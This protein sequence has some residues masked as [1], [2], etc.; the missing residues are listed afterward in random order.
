MRYKQLTVKKRIVM[1][2]KQKQPNCTQNAT[3]FP[4]GHGSTVTTRAADCGRV[5]QAHRA[6]QPELPVWRQPAGFSGHRAGGHPVMAG[7]RWGASHH[8]SAAAGSAREQAARPSGT[9]DGAGHQE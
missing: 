1:D 9:D 2:R 3:K 5:A 4:D 6:S 8:P 7:Q